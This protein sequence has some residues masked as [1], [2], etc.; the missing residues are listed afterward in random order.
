MG[1]MDEVAKHTCPCSCACFCVGVEQKPDLGCQAPCFAL[2][3][4]FTTPAG[5][6]DA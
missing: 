1:E 6:A 4:N 2:R 5:D 3:R